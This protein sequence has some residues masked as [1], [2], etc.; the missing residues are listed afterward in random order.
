MDVELTPEQVV[1]QRQVLAV[2]TA[3]PKTG[4]CPVCGVARCPDWTSAYDALAAAGQTM[5]DEPPPWK[6]FRPS[7]GRPT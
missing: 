4:V 2:H 1:Y 5:T 3:D 6:P 7:P